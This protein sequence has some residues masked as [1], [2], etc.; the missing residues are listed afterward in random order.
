[1]P[2]SPNFG[3]PDQ[4]LDIEDD[5]EKRIADTI[6]VLILHFMSPTRRLE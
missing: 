2:G 1:M 6:R 4:Q 3:L 5:K